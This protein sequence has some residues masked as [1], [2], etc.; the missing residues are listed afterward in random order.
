MVPAQKRTIAL[1]IGTFIA[2][3]FAAISA[4]AASGVDL[5][6]AWEHAY[7]GVRELVAAWAI[8]GPVLCI[9]YGAYKAATRQKL[10]DAVAAPDAAQAARSIEPTPQAVTVANAL[11][12]TP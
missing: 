12:S 10:L 8:V 4:M 2:G 1:H 7:T 5:Y 3:S 11:K 9:G 6:S